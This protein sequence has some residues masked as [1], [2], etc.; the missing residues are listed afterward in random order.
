MQDVEYHK[1]RSYCQF[2]KDTAPSNL[3]LSRTL[4]HQ[5]FVSQGHCSIKSQF[6]KDTAPSNVR[7]AYKTFGHYLDTWPTAFRTKYCHNH[8]I[9]SF[10]FLCVWKRFLIKTQINKCTLFHPYTRASQ[11]NPMVPTYKLSLDPLAS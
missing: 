9:F 8:N 10:Q 3:S 5:I 11:R 2:L 6:L 4:F 1:W 7:K